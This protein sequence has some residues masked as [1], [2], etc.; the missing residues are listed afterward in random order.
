M[1]TATRDVP[2]MLAS[3]SRRAWETWAKARGLDPQRLRG[4][5]LQQEL[6]RVLLA[7]TALKTAL[8]L[9]TPDEQLTLARLKEDGGTVPAARSEERRVGKECRW[10]WAAEQ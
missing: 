2:R 9:T 4:P 10:G 8:A 5:A 1:T 6:A 7:P 3:Y